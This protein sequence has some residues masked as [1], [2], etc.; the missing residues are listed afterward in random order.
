MFL[1][2][3]MNKIFVGII[4]FLAILTAN[5]VNAQVPEYTDAYVNDFA[6]VL[7]GF[8][9]QQFDIGHDCRTS[10]FKSEISTR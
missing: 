3:G 2:E 9:E 4:F 7:D 8:F 6:D 1:D 5:V 10:K